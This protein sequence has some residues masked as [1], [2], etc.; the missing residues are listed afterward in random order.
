MAEGWGGFGCWRE[1]GENILRLKGVLE[2]KRWYGVLSHCVAE[3]CAGWFLGGGHFFVVHGDV[4]ILRYVFGLA[5]GIMGCKRVLR[6]GVTNDKGGISLGMDVFRYM[7]RLGFC[8]VD[9]LRYVFSLG[10]GYMGITEGVFWLAFDLM[11]PFGSVFGRL[12]LPVDLEAM[13]FAGLSLIVP[14]SLGV[15]VNGGAGGVGV[16]GQR[17]GRL[18]ML[19]GGAHGS[20]QQ[21][22]EE[23]LEE[24]GRGRGQ[25]SSE[26]GA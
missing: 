16:V 17:V 14:C 8:F 7:F 23:N 3:G 26:Y 20:H 4:G 19:R 13:V 21:A 9:V 5:V 12:L 22:R 2:A 15:L 1:F 6:I 25:S 11:L 24:R 10:F 18:Q